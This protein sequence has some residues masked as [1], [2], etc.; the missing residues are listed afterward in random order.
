MFVV[1]FK[2]QGN[3]VNHIEISQSLQGIANKVKNLEGCIDSRVY[4][5]INNNNIFLLVEEWQKQRSLDDHMKSNLFAALLGMKGLLEN[6][7]EIR[8]LVER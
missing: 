6:P 3:P 4:T 1:T 8:F 2:L 5:D 7:P